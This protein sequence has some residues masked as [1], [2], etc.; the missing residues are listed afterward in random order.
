MNIFGDAQETPTDQAPAVLVV[1]TGNICRSPAGELLLQHATGPAVS[2]ASAGTQ[3]LPKARVHPR[4]GELLARDAIVSEKFR[5]RRIRP[6]MAEGALLVLTATREHR[7]AVLR[8]APRVLNRTFTI[9][10]FAALLALEE[11]HGGGRSLVR[12]AAVHR[13]RCP[14]RDDE[15]DIEDPIGQDREVFER[16]YLEIKAAMRPIAAALAPQV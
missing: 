1:C 12:S 4:M 14:L 2:V 13:A 9:K 10:E 3:G 16:V 7:A 6:E 5:S 15:L 8:E 11:V